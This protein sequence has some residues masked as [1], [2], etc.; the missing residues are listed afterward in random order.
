MPQNRRSSHDL[1]TRLIRVGELAPVPWK[2][3]GGVTREIRVEPPEASLVDFDWRLSIADVAAEGP[4]SSFVGID[5]IIVLTK[6]ESM[7]LHDRLAGTCHT[8]QQNRPFHFAGEAPIDATLPH[9][10]TQDFNLMWRRDAIGA[11][12]VVHDAAHEAMSQAGNAVQHCTR[13]SYRITL[14]ASSAPQTWVLEAGDTLMLDWPQGQ[15]MR[16]SVAPGQEGAHLLD[17]QLTRL[18]QEP[19][20]D[21]DYA[22]EQPH[23]GATCR[24]GSACR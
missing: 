3:G 11:S 22:V 13:G 1:H 19:D 12:L 18:Q 9:G 2:N 24:P 16:W 15:A 10:P 23:S 5:R 21:P 17:I 7:Q 8:L 14:H 20:L 6:G 4:F